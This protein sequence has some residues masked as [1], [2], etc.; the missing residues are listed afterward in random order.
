[1]T[2]R[3]AGATG[4]HAKS[5]TEFFTST[6]I[7][8]A[9]GSLKWRLQF[10]DSELNTQAGYKKARDYSGDT[11][12]D[13]A[14]RRSRSSNRLNIP[15]DRFAKAIAQRD[16]DLAALHLEQVRRRWRPGFVRLLTAC[17]SQK[18]IGHGAGSF[19]RGSTIQ[20]NSRATRAG[21]SNA[22]WR[23]GSSK[24]TRLTLRDRNAML[25]SRRRQRS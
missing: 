21:R 20:A 3:S 19:P 18:K 12:G 11:L 25:H 16:V 9:K 2:P 10:G 5:G 7:A 8:A 22:V 14:T 4:A 13:G 23:L 1:M 24:R 17:W 15:A 6:E